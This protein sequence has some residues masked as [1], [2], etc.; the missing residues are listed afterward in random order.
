MQCLS[1]LNEET[2]ILN[3]LQ[4]WEDFSPTLYTHIHYCLLAS[5]HLQIQL[6]D[7]GSKWYHMI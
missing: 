5:V 1:V 3:T 4:T 2:Q 6:S 7:I